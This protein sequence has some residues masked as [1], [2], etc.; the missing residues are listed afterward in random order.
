MSDIRDAFR[1]LRA[2]PI[3]TLVAILS[4]LASVALANAGVIP[5][6]Q[7]DAASQ[8]AR[9]PGRSGNRARERLVDISD[10]GTGSRSFTSV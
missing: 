3:V 8:G 1:T 7:L 2:T 9:P 6:Q 5:A 4:L 10:L